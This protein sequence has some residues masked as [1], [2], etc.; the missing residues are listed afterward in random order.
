MNK[1]AIQD[2]IEI[3]RFYGRQKDYTLA[4]GGNTSWKDDTVIWVKA[5]GASL[6]EI[7]ED[8]FAVLYREKVRVTGIKAYSRDEQV[9]ET[10]VKADL[11]AAAVDPSRMKR[12]SV[13][14]S[15]HELIRYAFVIHMHP[16]LTNALMCS[17]NAKKLSREL[18]GEEAMYIGYAPGYEL[19]KKVSAE[20]SLYRNRFGKDP[21][22]IFLENHGVF[23]SA[24]TTNE[25][26][27]LYAHITNTI[28]SRLLNME[29]IKEL[30]IPPMVSSFL[31]AMRMM[32]AGDERFITARMRHNNLHRHFY[33]DR[34]SF[35]RC[36]LPFTPDIIVYCKSAY[37][38]LENTANPESILNEFS[39]KLEE[40]R[41]RYHYDPKIVMIRNYGLVAFEESAQA[42]ETALD[43]YEDLL[44]ISYYSEN[45]GGPHFLGE[46]EI[47]FIDN[48]EVENYR[49]KISKGSGAG[50][51][52]DQRV[53]VITGGAQGFG[54]GLAD[55]LVADGA[56]VVIADMNKEAG[57]KKASELKA[58]CRRNDVC[59][60]AV[61]VADPVSVSSLVEE[62]VKQFGGI[63]VF[64][65]N[66]GI[67][68]AGGLDEMDPAT[69]SL[70]TKVNYEG[71]FNCAKIAGEVMRLQSA[72]CKNRYFDLVQINSK[73]GLR[74]SNRNF[75]YAGGKFGG[76]GLTQSFALE[77]A[78]YRIKVNAICP[79]NFFEGPL[80]SDPDKGLFVQYLRAGKVPGAKTIEDVRRFYEK[81][82]PMGR[83]CRVED[84]LKALYYI[85]VQ[86]YETG[87]AIP[88]TGGQV[89]LN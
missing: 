38:Y 88:V 57:Q 67:L 9:R 60:V 1:K 53:V 23:V 51:P 82:V 24:D 15:F 74:G 61:N 75:A 85:M 19:F 39:I 7:D 37:L 54:G 5:S 30:D 36:S 89:M 44:K 43:V 25:V 41:A 35:S 87:Q 31:P 3:S 81:Q 28:A 13:E 80:W 72:H 2:L 55:M 73:S 27:T 21:H 18:F 63:D 69:F 34:E 16:T 86:N 79:G 78:P 76:I 68:H 62:T 11:E 47:Q 8:G 83:G 59:F 42:A 70:M 49:R 50:S 66:A 26:K 17:Q 14:T 40:F 58:L 56:N 71:Y 22:I 20:I 12:P 6:A 64:I 48:W 10:E 45:F 29:E 84:V 4:G 33:T 32:V 52:A 46:K 65:S 77:L